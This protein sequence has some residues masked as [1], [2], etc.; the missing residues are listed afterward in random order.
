LHT[1]SNTL[2]AKQSSLVPGQRRYAVRGDVASR[3]GNREPHG[4]ATVHGDDVAAA[5]TAPDDDEQPWW[6][7]PRPP[8]QY[9]MAAYPLPS[10]AEPY[11]MFSDDNPNNCLVM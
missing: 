3:N 9:L 11:N 1:C 8:M 7:P 2:L 6:P 4:A 5:T 10:H